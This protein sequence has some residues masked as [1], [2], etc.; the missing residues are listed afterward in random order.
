MKKLVFGKGKNDAD[1]NTWITKGGKRTRCQYYR[2]WKNMLERCYS[3]EFQIKSPAYK[4]CTVAE[5]W[6]SFMKFRSWMIEQD[7]EGKVLDKDMLIPG[8]KIYGPHA[9]MFIL[10]DINKLLTDRKV[11]RGIYPQGVSSGKDKKKFQARISKYGKSV[12]IGYYQTPKQAESAYIK[13]KIS[14]IR[15]VAE[16]QIDKLADALRR[17]AALLEAKLV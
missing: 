15:N 12:Y 5:E 3:P 13:A 9:C 10:Q 1:Y 16:E 2:K 8:N 7:Y 4:G 6:H 17:H 11:A 14:H